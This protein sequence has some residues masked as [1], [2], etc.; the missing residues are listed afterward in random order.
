MRTGQSC[1]HEGS[2]DTTQKCLEPS[3]ATEK[4]LAHLSLP[5]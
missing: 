2:L 3:K 4:Q 1:L 5:V